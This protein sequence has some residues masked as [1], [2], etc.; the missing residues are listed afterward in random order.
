MLLNSP[1]HNVRVSFGYVGRRER[2]GIYHLNHGTD[3][4]FSVWIA[5]PSLRYHFLCACCAHPV[6]AYVIK[7]GMFGYA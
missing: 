3:M 4:H 5:L 7:P 6:Q 1:P 2:R